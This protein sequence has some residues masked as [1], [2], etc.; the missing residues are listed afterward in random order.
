MSELKLSHSEQIEIIKREHAYE[1]DRYH[2]SMNT[3]DDTGKI[4]ELKTQ[5]EQL[6]KF[7]QSS[8]QESKVNSSKLEGIFTL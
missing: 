8:Y 2:Q 3:N 5:M 6:M 4:S 7:M 1:L